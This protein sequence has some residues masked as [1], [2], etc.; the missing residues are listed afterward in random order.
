SSDVTGP[1]STMR[2]AGSLTRVAQERGRASEPVIRDRLAHL[3][4]LN[5][6][7][8]LNGLR[9]RAAAQAGKQPGPESSTGKL[10]ASNASRV[11]RD[12][13]LQI[14]G[15]DGTLAAPDAPLGGAL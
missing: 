7:A 13:G 2:D 8:N 1:Y 15:A 6:V 4:V 12:L 11:A 9:A 5:E 14:L 10:T 3:R